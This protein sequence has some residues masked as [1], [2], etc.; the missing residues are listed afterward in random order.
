MYV[1]LSI[2]E[3]TRT[4]QLLNSAF[5]VKWRISLGLL[6]LQVMLQDLTAF[7]AQIRWNTVKSALVP[8]APFRLNL[9]ELT[10]GL[11][12]RRS[13]GTVLPLPGKMQNLFVSVPHLGLY[14]SLLTSVHRHG[15]MPPTALA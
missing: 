4:D 8:L 3:S 14:Q 12:I 6:A 1:R 13:A 5:I 11:P 10:A 9:L 7:I 15:A 2:S